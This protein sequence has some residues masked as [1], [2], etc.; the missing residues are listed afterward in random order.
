LGETS[1]ASGAD[2][3][4]VLVAEEDARNLIVAKFGKIGGDFI[5]MIKTASADMVGGGGERHDESV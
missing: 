5:S 3:G 1:S 2:L 4:S